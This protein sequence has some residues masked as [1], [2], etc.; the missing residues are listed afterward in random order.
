MNRRHYVGA[1]VVLG[2]MGCNDGGSSGRATEEINNDEAA[3]APVNS[4]KS[5]EQELKRNLRVLG[6]VEAAAPTAGTVP[7]ETESAAD[8]AGMTSTSTHFSAT[9]VQETGVDESDMVKYDGRYLYV[10]T[11][12]NYGWIGLDDASIRVLETQSAPAAAIERA[13]IALGPESVVGMY[14]HQTNTDT[15]KQLAV[16]SSKNQWDYYTWYDLNV[17][18]GT[19]GFRL[20]LIDVTDPSQSEKTWAV[21]IDG[22]YLDSRRIDNKL[23]VISRYYPHIDSFVPYP[24]SEVVASRNAEIVDALNI[25]NLLPERHVNGGSAETHVTAEECLVPEG[26]LQNNTYLPFILTITTFDLDSPGSMKVACMIGEDS[27]LYASTNSLYLF[28]QSQWANTV[29]HKFDL[30]ASGAQYS[31]S[32]EIAGNVGWNNPHLRFSEYNHDLRIMTTDSAMQHRLYVL[33]EDSVNAGRLTTIATLPNEQQP[34]TIGKPNEALYGV[35]FLGTRAYA[36]TFERTD[37]LYVLDLSNPTLPKVAGELE[38]PGFSDYLQPLGENLLLGVG[39]QAT[40]VNGTTI[41]QGVKIGL[42]DTSNI[43]APQVLHEE[44]LGKQGS[45][46]S[47]A[48]DYHALSVLQIPDSQHYRVVLPAALNDGTPIWGEGESAYYPWQQSLFRLFEIDAGAETPAMTSTGNIVVDT[49]TSDHLW[50]NQ[51]FFRSVIDGDNV[52]AV[53]GDTVWS[54]R[55]DQPEEAVGPQ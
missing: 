42:F 25:E 51:Y 28:D 50:P 13:N 53:Y 33:R 23:Y 47:A 48:Y 40:Q 24:S 19:S 18:G 4:L 6:S 3:L 20:D 41:I 10:T 44:I 22:T 7:E 35:R 55:W 15:S 36:V 11:Q 16:I 30:T 1:F 8:G 37:P 9:N 21:S 27:G 38:I 45:E 17:W 43:S 52:H 39:K 14:F 46:T 54:A 12:A 49:V 31:A 34:Q 32:G 5:L 26:K 29:I 2:L